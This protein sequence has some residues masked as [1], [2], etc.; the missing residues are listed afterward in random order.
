MTGVCIFELEYSASN[1]YAIG[2]P[3]VHQLNLVHWPRQV[4]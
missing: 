3:L 1:K 2:H 4:I